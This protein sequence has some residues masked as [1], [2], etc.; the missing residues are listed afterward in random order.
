MKFPATLSLGAAL[1]V[2]AVFAASAA[3]AQTPARTAASAQSAQST[4]SAQSAQSAP[5][6]V[7]IGLAAP[8]TGP[9]ARIGKDLQNGAQLAL[10]DANSRH[11]A[12]GGKPVV[13]KLVA[14]D[15]Q[16]DPRTAVT[17]AQQLVE[18]RVIGV[19]GHWN[20]GCSVPASRIYRDAGIAQI[21]PASTGHQYTRQG[22]ATAFRIM[23]HDDAG[24]AHAGAYVVKTLHAKRIAVIDDRTAFGAGLAD[25]FV[26]GVEANGG[27]IVDRQ[28][29]NDKTTDF[30]AVLTAVK[31]K[32]ADVVFF[33]GLDAQAAPLARRMRQLKLGAML[34]GAGGFVTQT[35]LSLAG[36]DGDGVTALEPGLP[37]AGMPGGAAFD[38]RYR[39]RYRAPIELHAPFAYDAAATLIA[40]AERAN[41]TDPA[42]L[43]AVL[44]A[45]K[46]QGVTGAIAFDAEGNLQDPAFTIYRAGGGK[47]TAVDVLGGGAA[48]GTRVA[49]R[50]SQTSNASTASATSTASK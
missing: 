34:V 19:V 29:V 27:A 5:Q 50:T 15:D 4:Q 7:L 44:H 1:S 13:Y 10:D 18:R 43:P 23:G 46:R 3:Q 25:Q 38:A 42:R 49:S 24:G 30:S 14:V 20:T 48:T 41:S 8:L 32:R 6:T 31:A 22:Y 16:S 11:P 45:L 21:A 37:L 28:Y 26:K 2:A 33:G 9:S 39:A 40:A 35:F 12:L 47:W 17:V 36:P